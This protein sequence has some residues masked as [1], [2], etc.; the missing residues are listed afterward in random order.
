MADWTGNRTGRFLARYVD[1]A[2]MGEGA[3]FWQMTGGTVELSS[4]S[5]TKASG[6]IDFEGVAP[7]QTKLLRIYYDFTDDAG[8]RETVAVGTFLV[9]VSDETLRRLADGTSSSGTAVLE[10][11]LKVLKDRM[12]GAA[13]QVPSGTNAVALAKSLCEAAGLSVTGAESDYVTASDHA[14]TADESSYIVMVTWLLDKAGFVLRPDPYGGVEFARYVEPAERDASF[15]FAEGQR[16]VM[17]PEAVYSSNWQTC[18]N[19]VRLAHSTSE[20]SLIAWALNVDEASPASLPSRGGREV[21]LYEAVSDLEGA[22]AA[23]RAANLERLALARLVDAS[24]E[25]ERVEIGCPFLPIRPDM[26]VT[27]DYADREWTGAVVNVTANLGDDADCRVTAR[28][29]VRRNLQTES[30]NEVLWVA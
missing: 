20:E 15:T 29:F 13:Y 4:L 3:E 27:V 19:A 5:D 26:A 16:S 12:H 11:V 21:T 22:D 14:F 9:S 24:A 8:E 28:R 6:T 30:G 18:P 23:T 17:L 25:V 10:S 7:D 2:T 1:W